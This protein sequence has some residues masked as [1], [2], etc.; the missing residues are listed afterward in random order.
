MTIEIL[1]EAARITPDPERSLKNLLTFLEE[2]PSKEDEFSL[3][4]RAISLL[5]SM[6]QFLANY[7]IK[8]PEV[9]LE[10]LKA[11]ENAPDKDSLSSSLKEKRDTVNA[12][13]HRSA[14]SFYMKTMREFR[15]KE[16]L[17][18][19]LRDILKKADLVDIMLE[20]SDLADV[21]IEYSL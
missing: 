11:L 2:N 17:R 16:L 7:S 18:I 12:E 21:S 14:M 8:N 3:Y 13:S 20:L 5:F 15:T 10:V 9:L 1:K 19:T 4:I 6:S